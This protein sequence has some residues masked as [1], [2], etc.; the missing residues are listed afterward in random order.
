MKYNLKNRPSFGEEY[1]FFS[2]FEAWFEGFERELR[3]HYKEYKELAKPPE[4]D[5]TWYC[6]QYLELLVEEILGDVE[7]EEPIKKIPV[8]L[9][10]T[11][12]DKC[13]C[14]GCGYEIDEEEELY[15]GYGC[16]ICH[17]PLVVKTSEMEDE[18]R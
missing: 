12:E 16:P 15:R 9:E 3:E 10:P 5:E 6:L 7:A 18:D 14:L 8:K 1:S 13:I 11:P 17:S 2:A 4:C